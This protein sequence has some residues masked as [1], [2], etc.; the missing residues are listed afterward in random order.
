[1]APGAEYDKLCGD[2]SAALL[3][4]ENPETGQR[5]VQ[6][7]RRARDLYDGP[8]FD[9]LPDLFVE[10]HH[11]A[12]INAL[13][14]PRIGTVSGA[15]TAERSG[16]HWQQGLLLGQGPLFRHGKIDAIRTQDI[17]PTLLDLLGVPIPNGYEGRSAVTGLLRPVRPAA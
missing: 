6:W 11:E 9:S 12:P 4:L 15:M 1:V 2:L 17:A 8:R 16:D 5:A 7:V 13:R 3:E 10:W 14:S